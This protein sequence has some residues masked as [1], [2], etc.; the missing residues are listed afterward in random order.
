MQG[1]YLAIITARK[2]SKRLFNK[3]LL[4]LA[5]KPL[6]VWTIEAALQSKYISKVLVSTDSNEI[7]K[8][9]EQAGALVPFIRPKNLSSDKSTS[10]DVIIHVIEFMESQ[11]KQY[12]NFI[13]L[14]P[15]SPLR[16]AN[17]I[18]SA[19]NL[20][21]DKEANS[22]TSVCEMDHSPLWSNTL[23]ENLAMDHFLRPEIINKRSQ[24]LETYYRLNGAIYVCKTQ[25]FLKEKTFISKKKSFA[26]IMNKINSIDIDDELDFK[27]AEF[28]INMI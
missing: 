14:Q 20:H 8:I 19:I 18:D 1:T 24:D 21:I 17:D 13:L 11:G 2:G 3:N 25:I 28:L 15:T 9:S 5:G 23:P 16:T 26:F 10:A 27:F 12:D 6:I 4:L 22:V 7:A